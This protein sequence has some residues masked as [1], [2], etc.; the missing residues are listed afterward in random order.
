[1]KSRATESKV[2]EEALS[3]R[4]KNLENYAA[5]KKNKKIQKLVRGYADTLKSK[6]DPIDET[7]SDKEEDEQ[8]ENA[9]VEGDGDGEEQEE[10][11]SEMETVLTSKLIDE[12]LD[13]NKQT[14]KA[15]SLVA[16]IPHQLRETQ[17]SSTLP[18]EKQAELNKK[19]R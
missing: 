11:L 5:S 3:K 2:S 8:P 12:I 9:S 13:D 18:N 4:W 19:L 17:M 14:T 15:S 16:E 7:R 10:E 1:M 6:E